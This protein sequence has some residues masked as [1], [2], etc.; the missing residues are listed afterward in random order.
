[1]FYPTRTELN[2]CFITYFYLN[3]TQNSDCLVDEKQATEETVCI[4][5]IYHKEHK[6]VRRHNVQYVFS[7]SEQLTS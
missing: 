5:R 4:F 6:L 2:H 7:I 1:M 3:P